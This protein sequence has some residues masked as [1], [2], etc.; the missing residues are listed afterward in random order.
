MWA[1]HEVVALVTL[2]MVVLMT[3]FSVVQFARAKPVNKMFFTGVLFS[4]GLVTFSV[5]L[6]LLGLVISPTDSPSALNIA[7]WMVAIIILPSIFY[8]ERQSDNQFLAM[9]FYTIGFVILL[10]TVYRAV[11]VIE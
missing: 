10:I 5:L 1:L 9:R 8:F 7:Y 4:G 2:Q 11:A 3:V 6:A